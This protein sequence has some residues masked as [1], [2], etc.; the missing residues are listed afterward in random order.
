MAKGSIK[1]STSSPPRVTQG[2]IALLDSE[3]AD[4]LA[5][6][7]EAQFRPGNDPSEPVFIEK[8]DEA[9]RVYLFTPTSEP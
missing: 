5:N 7:L 3:K 1:F 8:V 6:S 9:M 2:V 4:A